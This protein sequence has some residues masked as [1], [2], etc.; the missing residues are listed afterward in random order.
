MKCIHLVSL[1][2]HFQKRWLYSKEGDI[3]AW[4]HK[5]TPSTDHDLW[6]ISLVLPVRTVQHFMQDSFLA[7]P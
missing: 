7:V 2:A 3:R 6:V 1:S 5:K 4:E